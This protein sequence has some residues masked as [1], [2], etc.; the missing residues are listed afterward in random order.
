AGSVLVGVLQHARG[1]FG[2][3]LQGNLNDLLD[4]LPRNLHRRA[5][6]ARAAHPTAKG[7]IEEIGERRAATKEVLQ[8]LFV[9]GAIFVARRGAPS[10]SARAGHGPAQELL[11]R[12]GAAGSAI[13]LVL[14]PARPQLVVKPAL[15]WIGEHLI[16]LVDLLEARLGRFVAGIDIGVI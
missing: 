4:V 2:R 10:C 11:G 3:L 14:A 9:H 7:L 15:L 1:A 8:V 5:T 12:G 13:L 6:P 16:G